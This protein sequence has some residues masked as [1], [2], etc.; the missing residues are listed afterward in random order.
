[1]GL[2]R[3]M[4][5]SGAL[6]KVTAVG[7]NSGGQW[8][9]TQLLWSESFYASIA[10]NRPIEDVIVEWGKEYD[11]KVDLNPLNNAE[12]EELLLELEFMADGN[13]TD[14]IVMA[15][16]CNSRCR[17]QRIEAAKKAAKELADR[18]AR[19]ARERAEKAAQA[20]RAAAEAAA[21]V[22]KDLADNAKTL[23]RETAVAAAEATKKA[24]QLTKKVRKEAR[25]NLLKYLTDMAGRNI[26]PSGGVLF[27]LGLNTL[28]G[29]L[30]LPVC[31]R[32][33]LRSYFSSNSKRV[34]HPLLLVLT[35]A[36]SFV[37]V[38]ACRPWT[39]RISLGACSVI[40][41]ATVSRRELT[42]ASSARAY[43]VTLR[44]CSRLQCHQTRGP[45]QGQG[46]LTQ[47]SL[48]T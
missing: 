19:E 21:R 48:P 25:D 35:L 20:A 15:E 33:H 1:M 42:R 32:T 14:D 26:C 36:M 12:L 40:R 22:A 6:T 28:T 13:S 27:K 11:K 46:H 29:I 37:F 30:G 2:L 3:A 18:V 8:L 4:H 5:T 16:R 34:A 39:G 9:L 45:T 38:A 23:A 17:A 7:G 10:S 41:S 31:A 43:P 47:V 44:S 24:I